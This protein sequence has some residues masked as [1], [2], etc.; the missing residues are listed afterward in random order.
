MNNNTAFDISELEICSEKDWHEIE[1]LIKVLSPG[2]TPRREVLD[3]VL[4]DENSHLFVAR[5][6]DGEIVGMA[7]GC[8][9]TIPTGCHATV[10]DVV[11]LPAYQGLGLGRQ[12]VQTILDFLSKTGKD[13]KVGLTSKP[14]RVAANM[15]YRSMGFEKKETNV[16]TMQLPKDPCQG[17]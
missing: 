16:Y 10:E 12:L 17:K 1:G 9:F 3:L 7:T 6:K 14:S 11:V 15:L 5:H 2:T 8:S 4:S 13:Y